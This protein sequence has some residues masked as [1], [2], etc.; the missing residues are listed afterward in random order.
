MVTT[1]AYTASRCPS[2]AAGVNLS[3]QLGDQAT[4]SSPDEMARE[5]CSGAL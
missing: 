2:I 3:Y 5:L 1:S 4:S